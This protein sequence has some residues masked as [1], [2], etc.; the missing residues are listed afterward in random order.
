MTRVRTARAWVYKEQLRD[1]KISAILEGWDAD[2]LVACA[3][4]EIEP[5]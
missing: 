5:G 1:V 4:S 3:I 2:I